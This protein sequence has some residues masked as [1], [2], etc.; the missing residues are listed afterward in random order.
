MTTALKIT[1]GEL[2]ESP[3][4]MNQLENLM[5]EVQNVALEFQIIL[6]EQD[7]LDAL[8]MLA[9]FPYQAKSSL[10]LDFE[11]KNV[12]NEKF[13]FVDYIIENGD[14]CNVHVN[15]F[16]KMNEKINTYHNLV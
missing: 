16:K 15:T 5:R 6:T 10:Q 12:R 7:I 11:N 4:L 2:A 9:N 8:G 14:T 1:F 13:Y 3:D